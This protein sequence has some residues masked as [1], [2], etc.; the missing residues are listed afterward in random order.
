[1]SF[2]LIALL[3]S[4][5]HTAQAAGH[6]PANSNKSSAARQSAF[7]DAM[8]KLW[9]DHITWTR[10]FVVSA[11]AD[12]PDKAA[13]TQRLLQNQVDI[14]NAIKPF[15]GDAAGEPLTALLKEHI[16][17]A[18]ELVAAAKSNETAKAEDARKRWYANAEEI[19]AFL[20]GANPKAWPLAEMK[21]M[22]HDH[23]DLT[24]TEVV[25]RLHGDWA[26]DAA[27]YENIHEQILHMADM[28]SASII[29]QFPKK[30]E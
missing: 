4:L 2:V 6:T 27:A 29:N 15:Y 5:S 3:F 26:A 14:G 18:A 9:E 11:V 7:H 13:T 21:K 8:R 1:M 16:T 24:T 12:L 25:A 20:N 17:T 28:L 10:L 30:F 19:A 23:L 22:M